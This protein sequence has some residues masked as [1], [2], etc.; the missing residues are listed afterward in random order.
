[1]E[2]VRWLK[3][4]QDEIRQLH[5]LRLSEVSPS[6]R[7]FGLYVSTQR[8]ELA[9]IARV[10]SDDEGE[11]LAFAVACDQAEVAALAVPTDNA[12]HGSL[13]ALRSIAEGTQAPILRDDLTLHPNQLYA[14][15]LYGADAAMFPAAELDAATLADLVRVAASLHMASI[16]EVQSKEDLT[17]SLPLNR[18]M[19]GLNA[20]LETT[21]RLAGDVPTNRTIVALREPGDLTTA[22]ALRGHVD[23]VILG[24]LLRT[25]EDL[26]AIVAGLNQ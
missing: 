6:R 21:L 22:S 10:Q 16:I 24:T 12:R 13:A 5:G 23:A 18:V 26:A 4:K 11:N 15:R 8:Q 20:D 3:E 7:D 17:K 9:V 1:M 19:I 14:A 2:R 25:G